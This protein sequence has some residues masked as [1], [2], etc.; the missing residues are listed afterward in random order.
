M[1]LGKD[2]ELDTNKDIEITDQ[3]NIRFFYT[4]DDDYNEPTIVVLVE[5]KNSEK[6]IGL[7]LGPMMTEKLL[8]NIT[9]PKK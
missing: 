3:L 7:N 8:K 9:I 6:K 1:T 4:N 2:R 5:T